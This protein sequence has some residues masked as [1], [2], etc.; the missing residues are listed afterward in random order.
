MEAFIFFISAFEPPAKE[1]D[2][3]LVYPELAGIEGE[4]KDSKST[5]VTQELDKMLE[6]AKI[7]PEMIERLGVGFKSLSDNV[8]KM[9]S[10]SDAAV[11]TDEYSQNVRKASENVSMIND[12]YAKALEAVNS[13]SESSGVSKDYFEKMQEV[14]QKLGSLNSMYELELQESDNHVK[15]LN[16]FHNSMSRTLENLTSTENSAS[17][18]REEFE[19]LAT[20]LS[21][22]NSVYGN[23]LTA[24]T[25]NR[26]QQG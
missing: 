21:S 6:E 11:A 12:S 26:G 14:T 24:M 23:M 22:L 8:S 25:G 20:N 13:I 9:G 4:R 15:A 3:S 5:S 7:E 1:Y 10:L 19:Q 2:W 16:N 17:Q 18:F